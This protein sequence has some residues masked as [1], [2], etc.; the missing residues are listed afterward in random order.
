MIPVLI[1]AAGRGARLAELGLAWRKALI[2]VGAASL[3]ELHLATFAAEG[4]RRFILVVDPGGAEIAAAAR[5]VT[6]S[7]GVTLELLVQPE[8]RGIGNATALAEPLLCGSPFVLVLGDTYY[9]PE[10]L[11]PALKDVA[12]RRRAA[13]LSV[14]FVADEQRI[15]RE[16]TIAVDERGMVRSIVEKPDKILSPLKPCGVY[17]FGPEI[18]D[19][20]R[21]TP[22]SPLRGEVELTDAIQR[23]IDHTGNVGSRRTL[24]R[25]LNVT[26]PADVLWANKMWLGKHDLAYYLH[27]AAEVGRDV[28]ASDSV[29][30][31]DA[32]V[33]DRAVLDS[34]VV[35]PGAVVE[36]EARLS[37]T[38]V[39]PDN[40]VLRL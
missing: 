11:Q 29:V 4:A 18:F 19:A 27:P 23:L 2:P 36:S 5:A 10:D 35:F 6:D 37:D 38:L 39:V 31:R 30:A 34:V 8:P 17:F 33:G 22:P 25:D 9:E 32:I 12:R 20:L 26:Y 21:E 24:A 1:L 7:L 16:C 3:L 28:V 14:R 40:G 13:V 15:R